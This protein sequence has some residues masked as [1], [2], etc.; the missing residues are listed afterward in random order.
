MLVSWLPNL[1]GYVMTVYH[2]TDCLAT[3]F[4]QLLPGSLLEEYGCQLDQAGPC[5]AGLE[6][7]VVADGLTEP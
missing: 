1:Q 2:A 4:G 7:S 3:D 5:Q 6:V